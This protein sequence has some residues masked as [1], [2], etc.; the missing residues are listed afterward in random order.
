M[1]D[2]IPVSRKNDFGMIATYAELLHLEGNNEEALKQLGAAAKLSS[3]E[4]ETEQILLAQIKI[5]QA[6]ES[7]SKHIDELQA[8]L[9]AG[10][11]VSTARW[12]RLSRYYEA[13]RQIDKAIVA[14]GKA[15]AL[16]TKSVPVLI[17]SARLFELA[18]DMLAAADTNRKLAVLDRRYRTEYLTAV[19]K[20]EQRLG[21]R[22]QTLQAARDL[23]AASPG[24]P[25]VYKFYAELCFQ[26]G[27]QEEGL[28]ALRRSVRANPSDP[29]G[30]V[31]LANALSERVRQGEA[32]ELLWRAFEKTPELDAK[33]G[34]IERITQLYLE[35]NQFDRLL[36]RL[37]RE[38]READKTREATLCLA[39][40]YTTA[41]DLGEAR[42]Q[43]ERL[44]TENTRDTHLLSQLSTLCEQEGDLAA[45]VKYQRQLG[46]AASNNHDHQ[47]R[48]AQLLTRTGEPDEAAEIW[49]KL[50]SKD[51]EPHRNLEALD[52][53]TNSGKNEAALAILSRLLLQKPGN[54][55]LL[56]RE[57]S[58]LQALEKHEEA[59]QRFTAIL[60]L[61]LADDELGEIAKHQVEQAKKKPLTPA[62]QA[63]SRTSALANR[64]D[65]YTVPPLT[66]RASNMLRLRRT[67]GLDQQSRRHPKHRHTSIP[68]GRLWRGAH[69]LL[70]LAL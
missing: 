1:A 20:L 54:W 42:Q 34:V 51:A 39:Q 30:L 26:L 4:E 8:E 13:N 70:G 14:V 65:E 56:Y 57:A 15:Q 3:N 21:R 7:L 16:D 27:D 5:F 60:A 38:R 58:A 43:L 31:S 18:G 22:E 11:E 50:A 53:L 37:E 36:E 2:A 48:L 32:I 61:K 25:D 45:A 44:L 28:E 24:N 49:V 12:L 6:T 66:R 62:M 46:S 52:N 67:I 35:N 23:L 29:Q 40:A 64:F 68:S 17:A 69:C 19:T 63:A 47:L 59:G 10:K 9:D 41:G 55:E 33:L